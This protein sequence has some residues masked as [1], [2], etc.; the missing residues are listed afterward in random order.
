MLERGGGMGAGQLDSRIRRDRELKDTEIGG[1]GWTGVG[2]VSA[3]AVQ[4]PISSFPQ[5]MSVWL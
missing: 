3:L 1:G 4:L 5:H 2:A